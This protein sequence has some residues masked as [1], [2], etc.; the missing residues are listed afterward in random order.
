MKATALRL[1]RFEESGTIINSNL[2][3]RTRVIVGGTKR[4]PVK[5]SSIAWSLTWASMYVV[6]CYHLE[7]YRHRGRCTFN[8][9]T[10][11]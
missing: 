10:I 5:D 3:S 2:L 4:S 11:G 1:E 7:L 6:G 9:R 8:T